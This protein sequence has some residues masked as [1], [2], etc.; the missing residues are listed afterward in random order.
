VPPNRRVTGLTLRWPSGRQQMIEHPVLNRILTIEE[1]DS[2][3]AR[4]STQ[5]P[6]NSQNQEG[7]SVRVPRAVR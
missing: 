3:Q 4:H 5:K 1:S 6:Q 7:F 2:R